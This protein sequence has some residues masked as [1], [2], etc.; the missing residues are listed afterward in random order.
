MRKSPSKRE[1][2]S[3][4]NQRHRLYKALQ[5]EALTT[6]EIRHRLDILGVAPR[7]YELRH[8]HGYNIHT[9]WTHD[10]NP[11]GGRHSV[12]QYVLMPGKWEGGGH[13]KKT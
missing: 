10:D 9:H 11:G 12:A 6:L 13:A 5:E 3:A 4:E 2:Q 1:V 8:N 7:V